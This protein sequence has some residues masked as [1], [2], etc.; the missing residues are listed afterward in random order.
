MPC[1]VAIV[2]CP[3]MPYHILRRYQH[4]PCLVAIVDCPCMP[5]H[6]LRRYQHMPCLVAIVD[7]PCMPY[8]ILRRYQH[9]PCLVAIVD[10][11][12]MPYH[13]LRRYQH[14]PCL[15]AIVDCTPRCQLHTNQH[16]PYRTVDC[17]HVG[18]AIASP[19]QGLGKNSIGNPT[20]PT[21]DVL[22]ED[23][24]LDLVTVSQEREFYKPNSR[25]EPVICPV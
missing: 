13:I 24:L 8:H 10:C 3:C 25:N 22:V 5:Y 18:L 12:C 15:V 11:P 23:Q 6:I 14:M 19:L 7:C 21:T 16:K 4:M 17:P 2:D 9:M 20:T 1:L